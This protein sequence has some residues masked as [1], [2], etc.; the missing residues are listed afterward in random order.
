MIT[1]ALFITP[2]PITIISGSY[3]WTSPTAVAAQTFKQRS[4][5]ATAT[6]SPLAASSKSALNPTFEYLD[7]THSLRHSYRAWLDETGDPLGVQQR[8]MRHA[9]ISTTM[10]VYG[11]AFMK[12]KRKADPSVVRRVLL[13]DHTK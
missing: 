1:S 7:K 3:A 13:Q 11:G 5:I 2:P 10:N 4:R 9:N 8:L 12:A 6:L